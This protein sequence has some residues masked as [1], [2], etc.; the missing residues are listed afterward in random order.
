MSESKVILVTDASSGFGA[1]T[2]RALADA[3]HVVYAGMRDVYRGERS[4]G[5]GR[6]VEFTW[7]HAA[8][9]GV[10]DTSSPVVRAH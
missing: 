1:L 5:A 8:L 2:V 3:K 6:L 10:R 7:R 9:P 4:D